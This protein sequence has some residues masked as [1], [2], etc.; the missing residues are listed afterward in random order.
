MKKIFLLLLF[1][2]ISILTQGQAPQAISYQAVA[3]DSKGVTIKTPISLKISILD[4][5]EKGKIVYAETHKNVQPDS[6]GLYSL[7]IG[8]GKPETNKEAAKGESQTFMF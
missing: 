5:S 7:N 1:C 8:Q 6:N 3:Y 4:N 2:L